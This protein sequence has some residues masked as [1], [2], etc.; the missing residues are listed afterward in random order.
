MIA[1]LKIIKGVEDIG[2][3]DVYMGWL[4]NKRTNQNGKFKWFEGCKRNTVF[5][6]Y[7]MR[8]KTPYTETH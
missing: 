4:I 6:I 5:Q 3:D 1:V 2:C 8:N 7:T